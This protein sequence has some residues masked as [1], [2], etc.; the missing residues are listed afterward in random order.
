[1]PKEITCCA[2]LLAFVFAPALQNLTRGAAGKG[3]LE[4]G[5]LCGAI[6]H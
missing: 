5:N 4:N 3:A 1:M 6:T 2:L